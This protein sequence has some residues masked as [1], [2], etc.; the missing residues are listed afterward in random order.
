MVAAL[1]PVVVL[2]VGLL[3]HSWAKHDTPKEAGRAAI[4]IG[5]FY[6]VAAAGPH[7]VKLL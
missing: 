7:V 2:I 3:L 4:W 1:F 5:L 6:T